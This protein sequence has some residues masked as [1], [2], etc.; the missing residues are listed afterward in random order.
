MLCAAQQEVKRRTGRK[1]GDIRPQNVFLNSDGEAKISCTYSWPREG[2]NFNK[3]F[4]NEQTYL[5]PEEMERLEMG[6]LEDVNSCQGEI[7]SIG[8]TVLSAAMLEDFLPLYNTKT[9]RFDSGKC[10]VLLNEWRSNTVYSEIF[11]ALVSN[12][13]QFQPER[14]I[15]DDE[16]YKWLWQFQ[17]EISQ[18][19]D[20]NI[21]YAPPKIEQEVEEIRQLFPVEEEQQVYEQVYQQPQRPPV[22]SFE[23]PVRSVQQTGY[24]DRSLVESYQLPQQSQSP[25]GIPGHQT[26]PPQMAHSVQL[27]PGTRLTPEQIFAR[28]PAQLREYQQSQHQPGE[29]QFRVVEEGYLPPE[30]RGNPP[31]EIVSRVSAK[32]GPPKSP[33][34]F[35]N[36]EDMP[37]EAFEKRYVIADSPLQQAAR[38]VYSQD[39]GQNVVVHEGQLPPELMARMGQASQQE[40]QLH[41]EVMARMGQVNQQERQLPPE[42]VAR[43]RQDGQ[44]TPQFM[45]QVGQ[46]EGQLPPQ[47]VGRT[48]K[49][50]YIGQG[51]AGEGR[52]FH[53]GFVPSF[54]PEPSLGPSQQTGNL[55][56]F[57]QMIDPQGV[58]GGRIE[59]TVYIQRPQDYYMGQPQ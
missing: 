19:Q 32:Q 52:T 37:S 16:L 10:T 41:P 55:S 35:V 43:M 28:S 59:E 44:V 50:T 33:Q 5:A 56:D 58:R 57:K 40:R 51:Q 9:Y 45:G 11:T 1:V 38:K 17:S 36:Y 6:T 2:T 31:V 7:F 13:C 12:L 23:A 18:K 20:F 29:Q 21:D 14:R 25:R 53:Q 27:P 46:Q 15:D 8:L 30:L 49:E 3:T 4:D 47:L 24:P 48:I 34:R 42:L 39:F 22:P 54:G 26:L